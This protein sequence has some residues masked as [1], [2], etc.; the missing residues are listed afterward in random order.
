MTMGH[1]IQPAS[2]QQF[3]DDFAEA[4]ELASCDEAEEGYA[5]LLGARRD[6]ERSE[7]N[8]GESMAT[9]YRYDVAL[10]VYTSR[11]LPQA[12]GKQPSRDQ[13]PAARPGFVSSAR[14]AG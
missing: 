11:Y 13:E 5:A 2:F 9:A 10:R 14:Q 4:I 3:L 8:A 12:Q 1:D 6:A 7:S